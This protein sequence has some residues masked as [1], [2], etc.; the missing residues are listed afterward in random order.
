MAQCPTAYYI[1]VTI[2]QRGMPQSLIIARWQRP[3]GQWQVQS[4]IATLT[5][6][7][8]QQAAAEQARK[9]REQK[10]AQRRQEIVETKTALRKQFMSQFKPEVWVNESS[11]T[12]N[13]FMYKDKVVGLLATFDQMVAPSEARFGQV[14]VTD[15]PTSEF[16]NTGQETVLAIK[17]VGLKH[18][19]ILGT[20]LEL[21]Q[22]RYVGAYKC[23]ERGC[24]D[25]VE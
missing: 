3:T 18:A 7:E 14:F 10:E 15:V 1:Y 2:N 6:R 11:L 17:I 24:K 22:G 21:P 12:A 13:V 23:R 16:S 5:Q 19:K 20:D 9:D 25:F 4:S 8:E